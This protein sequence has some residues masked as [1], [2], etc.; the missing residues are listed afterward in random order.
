VYLIVSLALLC[1]IYFADHLSSHELKEGAMAGQ[2]IEDALFLSRLLSADGVNASNVDEALQVYNEIRLPRANKVLETSLE[3]GDV[4]EYYGKPGDDEAKLKEE[5]E[6]RFR[7]IWDVS[8]YAE[9]EGSLL[10]FF[11][12]A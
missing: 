11:C 10:T 8:R 4:Y 7:W 1:Y 12:I 6:S 2:A 3:A 9:R 5:L